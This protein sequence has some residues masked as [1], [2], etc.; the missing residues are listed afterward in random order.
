MVF[1]TK[2][3]QNQTILSWCYVLATALDHERWHGTD[4]YT[5]FPRILN[6]IKYTYYPTLLLFINKKAFEVSFL[7]KKVVGKFDV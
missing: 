3:Q 4:Y 5:V 1:C 6:T 2:A 7:N